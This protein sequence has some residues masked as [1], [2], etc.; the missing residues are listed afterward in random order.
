MSYN[1]SLFYLFFICLFYPIYSFSVIT[2]EHGKWVKS[3]VFSPDGTKIV[4]A[5]LDETA[6]IVDVESGEVL[7]TIKHGNA[8]WSAVFSP[9]GTKIVTASCYNRSL[10]VVVDI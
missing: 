8:V 10:F 6:K 3:A 9:D 5:S 7:S 2:I 4:T 1:K